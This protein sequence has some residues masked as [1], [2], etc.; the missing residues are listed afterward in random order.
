MS[1]SVENFLLKKRTLSPIGL[2]SGLEIK[3][4][5]VRM[6]NQLGSE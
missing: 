3:T 4:N 5:L 1:A 2:I 6:L